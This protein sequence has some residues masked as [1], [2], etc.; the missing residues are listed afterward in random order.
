M[1]YENF[2]A[3]ISFLYQN[4]IN[5]QLIDRLITINCKYSSENE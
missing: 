2:M 1:N 3:F 4:K 5:I